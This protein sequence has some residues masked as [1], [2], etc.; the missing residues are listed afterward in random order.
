MPTPAPYLD[1]TLLG[2]CMP[3]STPQARAA[4]AEPLREAMAQYDINTAERMAGFLASVSNETGQLHATKEISYY[5]TPYERCLLVFGSRMPSREVWESWRAQGREAFYKLSFDHLYSDVLWPRLGLGNTQPGDGSRYVGRGVGITGRALYA[6]YGKVAGIDLI[7]NPELL[8][9]PK[10]ATITIAA[11]WR[12]VG[13]NERMDR[14]DAYGAFKTL[15]PGGEGEF[16]DPHMGF[17]RHMLPILRS[18]NLKRATPKPPPATAKQAA[19]QAATGKTGKALVV[20]AAAGS[21]TAADAI[22]KIND[23]TTLATAGKGF[24]GIYGLPPELISIALGVV[25]VLAIGF[26]MWRY[27]YKLLHGKAVSE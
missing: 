25:T 7:N 13:N 14:G 10:W 27:G 22:D 19:K 11:M 26:V 21:M 4:W 6:K 12:D 2:R 9:E 24:L 17:Y 5:S 20:A 15:N 8:E 23:A 3:T 1:E 16:F 18:P